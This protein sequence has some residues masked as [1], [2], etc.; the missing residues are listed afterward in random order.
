VK[1]KNVGDY[2]SVPSFFKFKMVYYH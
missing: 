1:D 2:F